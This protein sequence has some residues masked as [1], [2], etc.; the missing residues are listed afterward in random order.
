MRRTT[1]SPVT[2]VIAVAIAGVVVFGPAPGRAASKEVSVRDNFFGPAAVQAGVGQSVHWATAEDSTA[3]H[4]VRESGRLFRS[5]NPTDEVDFSVAFSAGTFR[6]FCEV[7]VSF[8]MSAAVRVPV[9]LSAAPDGRAFTVRWATSASDTGSSYDVQYR[10]GS[11]K[12]KTWKSD[13]DA[14][15]AVFGKGDRP[16]RLLNGRTYS[17]RAR[18]LQSDEHSRWSPVRSFTT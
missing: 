10:A 9:R 1:A 17:F 7:H 8:G 3:F 13:T 15:K 5:G 18:S 12:W 16:I 11:D 4:N 2:K 14:G 6:Y